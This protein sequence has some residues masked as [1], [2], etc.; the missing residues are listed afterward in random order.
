[1]RNQSALGTKPGVRSEFLFPCLLHICSL[2][3]LCTRH[4]HSN[5]NDLSSHKWIYLGFLL[6]LFSPA[7]ILV[8]SLLVG[9][10]KGDKIQVN[11]SYSLLVELVRDYVLGVAGP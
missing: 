11:Y 5:I 1:M 2:M 4:S 8:V 6:F 3:F 10:E 9:A 7:Y